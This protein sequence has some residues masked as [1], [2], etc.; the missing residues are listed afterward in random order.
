MILTTFDDMYGAV[1]L[2]AVLTTITLA[3]NCLLAVSTDIYRQ[4]LYLSLYGNHFIW[5]QQL[6]ESGY[7][8]PNLSIAT[9]EVGIGTWSHHYSIL[10]REASAE[11]IQDA[12]DSSGVFLITSLSSC[13]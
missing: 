10:Q 13:L 8:E 12:H 2:C 1:S 5:L 9:V 7:L 6:D 3:R 11:L 4:G